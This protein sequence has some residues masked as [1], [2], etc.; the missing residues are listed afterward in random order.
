MEAYDGF[1]YELA[2]KVKAGGH[3]YLPCRHVPI[4]Q[5]EEAHTHRVVKH[6]MKLTST[7]FSF[8]F[9]LGA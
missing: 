1:D 6:D 9:C 2:R 8:N 5:G 7:I 4:E 3:P